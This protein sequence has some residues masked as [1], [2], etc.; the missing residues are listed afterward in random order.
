[1]SVYCQALWE[2]GELTNDEIVEFTS[3]VNSES[4]L[5]IWR[6]LGEDLYQERKKVLAR[7]LGKLSKPKEKIRSRKKYKRIENFLFEV[8]DCLIYKHGNGNLSPLLVCDIFQHKNKCLYS[9]T[10]LFIGNQTK[11]TIQDFHKGQFVGHKIPSSFAKNGF[12]YGFAVAKPEHRELLK[13]VNC[14][15]KIGSLKIDLE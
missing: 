13:Y 3:I 9:M 1:L 6:G 11:P 7:Q 10:P 14:F 15:S 4:G 5:K 12:Y 8:G 2:I